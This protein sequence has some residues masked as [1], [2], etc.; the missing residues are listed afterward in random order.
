MTWPA[1]G[2]KNRSDSMSSEV[3][4]TAP[5]DSP[6]AKPR[7]SMT[8]WRQVKRMIVLLAIIYVALCLL[9]LLGYTD[10]IL[11]QPHVPRYQDGK[12]ILKLRTS[13]GVTISAIYVP[14]P[15]ARYTIIFSHGNAEDMGDGQDEIAFLRSL[16]FAVLAYDY[17][18]Y[19]TS[20][21]KP[22]EE[23]CYRDIDAAYEYLTVTQKVP[24]GR[25]LLLGK[26]V[27]G[28]PAVDLAVRRPVGGLILQSTFTSAFRVFRIGYII[29]GDR[30]RNIDKIPRVKCPVLVIHGRA[31]EVAP[32]GHGQQLYEAVKGPKQ[33]LWV[34]RA[35][36]NDLAWAAGERYAQAF[37][38]FVKMIDGPGK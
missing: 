10:R 7:K 29:P 34:D 25:I 5:A 30:F 28:G 23:N 6:S 27:G 31:D 3:Q 12:D 15:A 11:F 20:Q 2:L 22:S 38:D 1:D 36:H 8:L 13:D 26:S 19:G 35:G 24:P 32:F 21:G 33:Y 16:G 4:K 18:G 37:T 17:H 14:N 9:P